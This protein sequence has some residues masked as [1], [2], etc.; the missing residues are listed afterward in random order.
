M[1]NHEPD[2]LVVQIGSEVLESA[3]SLLAE[4]GEPFDIDTH[5]SLERHIHRP[6][7]DEIRDEGGRTVPGVDRRLFG[8]EFFSTA[9]QLLSKAWQ[10]ERNAPTSGYIAP[11][12]TDVVPIYRHDNAS[13]EG[14]VLTRVGHLAGARIYP[15][16]IP[17]D[18]IDFSLS[19]LGS[20]ADRIRFLGELTRV[21]CDAVRFSGQAVGFGRKLRTSLRYLVGALGMLLSADAKPQSGA[22]RSIRK[23]PVWEHRAKN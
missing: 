4:C 9:S 13:V 3:L 2:S 11:V 12:G 20:A 18:A 19:L 15:V 21:Y 16:E 7:R 17:V 14:F 5:I 23:S 6:N 10:R 22:T 1:T 8:I